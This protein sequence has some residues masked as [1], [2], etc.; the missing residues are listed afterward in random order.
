MSLIL[1]F[2]FKHPFTCMLAGPSQSGKST[3]LARILENNQSMITPSPTKILY[4]YA[5][6]S[7]GFNKLNRHTIH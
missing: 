7:K 4:C 1:E 5:R 3:L 2:K 6:Y